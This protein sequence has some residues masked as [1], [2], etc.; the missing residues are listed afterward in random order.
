MNGAALNEAKYLP[1][2]GLQTFNIAAPTLVCDWQDIGNRYTALC[3]VVMNDGSG[4]VTVQ[5]EAS[6]DSSLVESGPFAPQAFSVSA[7][8]QGTDRYGLDVVWRYWR[9]RLSGT[10]TGRWGVKGIPR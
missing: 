7:S 10:S 9:L 4:A 2:L 8:L 6:E 3:F 5:A 1:G